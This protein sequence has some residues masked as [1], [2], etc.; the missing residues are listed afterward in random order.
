MELIKRDARSFGWWPQQLLCFGT[1]SRLYICYIVCMIYRQGYICLHLL[2]IECVVCLCFI[3]C[4]REGYF[5]AF[6]AIGWH[7]FLAVAAFH[8]VVV[9]IIYRYI[10]KLSAAVVERQTDIECAERITNQ[11][12]YAEYLF[13]NLKSNVAYFFIRNCQIFSMCT[14]L[15]LLYV[16][17]LDNYLGNYIQ[18]YTK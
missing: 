11:Y 8:L 16:Q 14:Q 17:L 4:F 7:R 13:Q 10:G 18:I 6:A 15:L 12:Q 5:L 3:V 2:Q 9:I 1:C